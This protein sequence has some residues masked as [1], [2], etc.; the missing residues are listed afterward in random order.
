[1]QDM[2]K[3]AKR[4]IVALDD[5]GKR[6]VGALVE[7]ARPFASTFKIGLSQFVAR[8]P[9]ILGEIS[10]REA[11]VFLDLK[12]HDI[13]MQVAKAVEHALAFSPRFLTVHAQGGR[14]MLAEAAEAAKGSTTVLLAVSVLTSLDQNDF[15]EIG[16]RDS[17]EDGVLRLADLAYRSGIR[18]LVSSPQEL[19]VLRARFGDDLFLVSPGV[20]PMD[21]AVFDQSR[22]M[23]PY[24]AIKCGA[25]A[26]VV[27]RPLTHADNICAKAC[28]INLEIANA[29]VAGDPMR[30]QQL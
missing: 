27:G 2:E 7:E 21:D 10:S 8:G 18:G 24:Q 3:A 11:D 28:M 6:D 22:V 19:K 30:E 5:I 9:A 20:R 12:L 1:M 15:S 29:L 25:D 23:T 4:L 17:I 14:K 26:L 16:Y 13:P